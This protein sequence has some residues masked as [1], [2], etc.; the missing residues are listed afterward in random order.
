MIA[1]A[2]RHTTA[3]RGDGPRS[4]D[5]ARA[6]RL[7]LAGMWLIDAALQF[8]PFMF[9]K[10]F[11]QTLAAGATGNAG[12]VAAPIVWNA[13][14]IEQHPALWNSV[15]ATIQLLIAAG[16][17]WRRTERAALGASIAWSLAI[18][19]F[20][21]GLGGMLAGLASPLTGAPGA[22]IV[23]ALL[24]VLLWPAEAAADQAAGAVVSPFVA[25]RAVG[26]RA[27]RL[28]WLVFWMVLAST[29]LWP[30][31]RAPQAMALQIL[32]AGDGEPSWLAALDRH[33]AV[34]VAERGLAV[35]VALACLLGLIAVALWLPAPAVK[36]VLTLAIALAAVIWVLGE[37]FGGILTGRA[38]DPNTGPL[39]AALTVAYWPAGQDCR[40]ETGL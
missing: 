30:Q 11:G 1:G 39:L 17:A 37:A 20:G 8:Q 14:L 7:A 40:V 38:T 25:A 32:M 12:V 4:A 28:L 34:W 18:W 22:V 9:T 5:A 31:N 29:A 10:A 6:L 36:P 26:S 35:P 2:L 15:Y 24:A 21:E 3:R 27:A 33:C 13:N 16:I 23:Y 19:W